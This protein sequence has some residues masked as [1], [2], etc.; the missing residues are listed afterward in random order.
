MFAV[1]A[2]YES[3]AGTTALQGVAGLADPHL[4]VSGD[5][6]GVPALTPKVIAAYVVAQ[7]AT[8]GDIAQAQLRSPSLAGMLYVDLVAEATGTGIPEP[9][10]PIAI[11]DMRYS[12][13]PLV[14]GE[15]MQ[16]FTANSGTNTEDALGLIFLA[17]QTPQPIPAGTPIYTVRATNGSTL[18]ANT[19]TNG[20]LTLGQA[21][22]AGNW[23]VVGMKAYSAGL[24]AARLVFANQ[25]P[26]PGCIGSDAIDDPDYE[27]FRR[28]NLGLWG[29][30]PHDTIPT[31]DFLSDS[32]DT[33]QVVLLDLIKL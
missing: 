18:V 13:L 2:F 26:R 6:I 16:L 3:R 31:V 24:Q 11:N 20:A 5:N 22:P 32:A 29:T 28:G 4:R 8:S 27:M 15:D 30:F 9:A 25:G 23:G 7:T 17:D 1:A 33:S 12:P 21:L 14:P 19:W 10:Y